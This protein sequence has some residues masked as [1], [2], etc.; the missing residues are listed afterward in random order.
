M[1]LGGIA[2]N[3]LNTC[4]GNNIN[5]LDSNLK[6]SEMNLNVFLDSSK[7]ACHWFDSGPGHHLSQNEFIELPRA[8]DRASFERTAFASLKTVKSE[9]G[10]GG[11]A[12]A[13]V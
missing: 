6:H 1:K 3:A 10:W 8:N 2:W 12:T 13:Q 4:F 9:P 11:M 7:S 5:R